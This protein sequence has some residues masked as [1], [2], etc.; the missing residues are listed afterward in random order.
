MAEIHKTP[1]KKKIQTLLLVSLTFYTKTKTTTVK[2]HNITQEKYTQVI[3]MSSGTIRLGNLSMLASIRL[4]DLSRLTREEQ[5]PLWLEDLEDILILKD[6]KR[7]YDETAVEPSGP[8]LEEQQ[9]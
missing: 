7:H 4:D 6:L 8:E 9:L 1:Q 5:W 2:Q 3:K